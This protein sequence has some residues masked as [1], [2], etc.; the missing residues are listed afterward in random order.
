M[1]RIEKDHRQRLQIPHKIVARRV[2]RLIGKRIDHQRRLIA[3]QIDS[4]PGDED[5]FRI[6]AVQV[7]L[8]KCGGVHKSTG[9]QNVIV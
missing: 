8:V 4:H 5:I 1:I 3:G 9:Y 6:V 2:K 7:D